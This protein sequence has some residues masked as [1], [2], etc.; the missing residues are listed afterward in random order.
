MCQGDEQA[1]CTITTHKWVR[2]SQRAAARARP[3]VERPRQ[4]NANLRLVRLARLFIA[5]S[6]SRLRMDAYEAAADAH[7]AKPLGV[8]T[9]H[10]VQRRRAATTRAAGA[11]PAISFKGI[12]TPSQ[13]LSSRD[14]RYDQ[15]NKE[16]SGD[17]VQFEKELHLTTA[18]RALDA[19]ASS[20]RD[21]E[22]RWARKRAAMKPVINVG[23]EVRT[24]LVGD[25]GARQSRLTRAPIACWVP[26]H[27]LQLRPV[28]QP[29]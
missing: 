24:D 17:R 7:V 2:P 9:G 22:D 6:F 25:A 4:A 8:L 18:T 29:L 1:L 3:S 5:T 13:Y 26:V 14:G 12:Q 27:A 19:S 20:K 10:P 23:T 15:R 16:C 11:A 21:I 28:L